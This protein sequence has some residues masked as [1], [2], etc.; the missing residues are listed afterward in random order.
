MKNS[1]I[2]SK[3][4]YVNFKSERLQTARDKQT[5]LDYPKQA[6]GTTRMEREI[7]I[8]RAEPRGIWDQVTEARVTG[9]RE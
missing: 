5:S 7:E 1:S 2:W 9:R 4:V 8:G 3:A 6:M